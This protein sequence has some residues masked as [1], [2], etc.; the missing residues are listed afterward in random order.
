MKKR[1]IFTKTLLKHFEVYVTCYCSLMF[2]ERIILAWKSFISV[3]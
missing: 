2:W 3:Q 1:T